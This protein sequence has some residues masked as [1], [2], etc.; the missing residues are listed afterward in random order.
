MN[1]SLFPQ[2]YS[3]DNYI[4]INISNAFPQYPQKIS[5]LSTIVL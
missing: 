3:Q 4:F 2:S 1:Y 5:K